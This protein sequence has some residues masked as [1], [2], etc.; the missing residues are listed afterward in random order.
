MVRLFHQCKGTVQRQPIAK[1]LTKVVKV[2][3]LADKWLSTSNKLKSLALVTFKRGT[4]DWIDE[5]R[6]DYDEVLDWSDWFDTGRIVCKEALDL[7]YP[8]MH[9]EAIRSMEFQATHGNLSLLWGSLL[10]EYPDH[11]PTFMEH[12]ALVKS[13]DESGQMSIDVVAQM[14]LD[15]VARRYK[16][17]G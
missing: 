15:E 10:S 3:I 16:R 1:W 11:V 14:Q 8:L 5:V 4:P 7:F 13:R 2:Y 9:L 12:L 6:S 17:M